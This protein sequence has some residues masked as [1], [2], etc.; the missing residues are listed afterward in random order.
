MAPQYQLI[1]AD[2]HVDLSPDR[3]T[4]RVSAKWRDRAPRLVKQVTE[5]GADLVVMERSRAWSPGFTKLSGSPRGGLP[6]QLPSFETGLGVGPPEQR[7]REQDQDG[8]QAEVMFTHPNWP[9]FWRGI[10]DDE[11][12]VALIHAYNEFLAEEYCAVAPDRLLAMGV[13]PPTNLK[14]ALAELEYCAR[15]GFKGVCLYKF[16]SAKAHP[17]PEDDQF[18]AATQDMQM[19][20]TDHTG[21]RFTPRGKPLFAYARIPKQ[22]GDP[23]EDLFRFSPQV[24]FVAMQLAYAGVFDRFPG[25]RI[26][27]A[28]N[29]IGWL[30]FTLW[31]SDDHHDRYCRM[32]EAL[33]GL[34]PLKRR[35]SDYLRDNC[36]WGFL[37]DPVGVRHRHEIGI[38]SIM[39]ATDFPHSATDWPRSRDIVAEMFS[40]VPED[41]RYQI[42]AGNAVNFFHMKAD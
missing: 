1:S 18:W 2:S 6:R 20:I 13:I 36:M 9:Q 7:L 19:P 4:H 40:G 29:Q 22:R 39:W 27:F 35:P 15:A 28:E 30:P 5:K 16:P 10:D 41:E 37:Y 33:W 34:E 25:L 26:Y 38:G 23:I 11:G 31:Q 21:G 8:V 42:V 32:W 3:W 17:V 12:Y 24:G 14:D